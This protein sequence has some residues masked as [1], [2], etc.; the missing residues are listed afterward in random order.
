MAV[1]LHT[2]SVLCSPC[3]APHIAPHPLPSYHPEISP[4]HHWPLVHYLPLPMQEQ[5]QEPC[6]LPA[7]CPQVPCCQDDTARVSWLLT[8][9]LE[10]PKPAPPVTAGCTQPTPC[11]T[12]WIPQ[13]VPTR[14]G[15]D[16][17]STVAEHSP[18]L[19]RDTDA[20]MGLCMPDIHQH[21]VGGS[22]LFPGTDGHSSCFLKREELQW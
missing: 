17:S 12:G 5:G 7:L 22:A 6:Q 19:L 4:P 20:I 9:P 16:V 1:T 21:S 10:A 15:G 11:C 8:T 2:G 18:E 14:P 13:A 3:P